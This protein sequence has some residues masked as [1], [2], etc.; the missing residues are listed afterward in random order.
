[1]SI[2]DRLK[3]VRG[4]VVERLGDWRDAKPGL[5][6]LSG[7]G[8]DQVLIEC[9]AAA[10]TFHDLLLIDGKYQV[11][12]EVP[13]FAGSDVVGRVVT[14]GPS[15]TRFTIGQ[16][17]AAIVSHGAFAEFA[18]ASE[19]WC[20]PVPD[21]M[22]RVKAAPCGTVFATVAVAL[23]MRGDLRSGERLLITGAS[24]GVGVAAI[25]YAGT[26]GAEIIALVSSEE[27]ERI[28][29][30]A[31]AHHVL[32]LDQMTNPRDDM[33]DA[34]GGAGLDGVD[35]VLD[36][37]GGDVFDGTI[38]CLAPGGRLVVV[39]F[40]SGQIPEVRTNY[41]LLKDIAVIGSALDNG[42]RRDAPMLCEIMDGIYKA[43]ARGELDPFVSEIFP[44][45]QF[46]K[47]AERIANRTVTGKIVLLPEPPA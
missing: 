10:L 6:P 44:F 33:R 47:A 17:V 35:V 42:F 1:M 31:G 30:R 21:D 7:P 22:D 20:F 24:G 34:L 13:F 19:S 16:R 28:A 40:A 15:V 45:D 2:E 25:Q 39:G 32:R 5:L 11:K 46:H 29:R 41:L 27:K 36:V 18:V 3:Q 26:L 43:V 23:T 12:P 37:V 9:E 8:P 4:I 14:L 38:R